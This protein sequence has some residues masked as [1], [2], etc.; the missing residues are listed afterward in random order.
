MSAWFLN[1]R[2][3]Q[4]I[5]VC[6]YRFERPLELTESVLVKNIETVIAEGVETK[7]QKD[8]LALLGCPAYQGYL[9]SRPLPLEAFEELAMRN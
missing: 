6:L 1:I 3:R 9:F 2:L 7:A 5:A 8:F 4:R